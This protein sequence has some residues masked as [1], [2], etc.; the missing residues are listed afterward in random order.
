[1]AKNLMASGPVMRPSPSAQNRAVRVAIES[2]REQ[3]AKGDWDYWGIRGGE[4]EWE[5][6][7]GDRT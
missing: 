3:Q 1:M 5:M 4:G 7:D 2:N 6:G